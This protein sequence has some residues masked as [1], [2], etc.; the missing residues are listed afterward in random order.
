MTTF[1]IDSGWVVQSVDVCTCGMGKG[2]AYGH[3]AFCGLQQECPVEEFDA[4]VNHM[5][6]QAYEQGQKD[7]RERIL[8]ALPAPKYNG[9]WWY[10]FTDV[11][12]AIKGDSDAD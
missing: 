9:E 4:W 2:S 12:R 3:E 11:Q 5:V 7:E 8:A 1:S 6:K 10:F